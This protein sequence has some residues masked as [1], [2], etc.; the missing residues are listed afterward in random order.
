MLC[1]CQAIEDVPLPIG[2]PG[3]Q[4][5]GRRWRIR[6]WSTLCRHLLRRWCVRSCRTVS[7]FPGTGHCSWDRSQNN[8]HHSFPQLS[9]V[10]EEQQRAVIITN[11]EQ[12][13]EAVMPMNLSR[14]LWKCS[15]LQLRRL[16]LTVSIWSHTLRHYLLCEQQYITPTLLY[17][18]RESHWAFHYIW[19][20][21]LFGFLFGSLKQ[22]WAISKGLIRLQVFN[23]Q[24]QTLSVTTYD[25][26]VH[27]ADLSDLLKL[28]CA[29]LYFKFVFVCAYLWVRMSLHSISLQ[30]QQLKLL[31]L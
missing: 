18:N 27:D 7:F 21:Y 17:E 23:Q 28:M 12:M 20:H 26:L 31:N 13:W 4:F 5:Y 16:I 1:S 3:I 6:C 30:F 19:S 2:S 9:P 14:F 25:P 15:L 29:A 10:T 11:K 8:R 22:V 24:N